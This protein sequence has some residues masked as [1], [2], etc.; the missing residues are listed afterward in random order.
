MK[1]IS[2]KSNIVHKRMEGD[3]DLTR[4]KLIGVSAASADKERT[5]EC[6]ADRD[7]FIAEP[8][9]I[10]A[11]AVNIWERTQNMSTQKKE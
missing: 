4:I 3:E 11:L 7:G 1:Y 5:E 2:K 6:A 9:H 8:V 10:K